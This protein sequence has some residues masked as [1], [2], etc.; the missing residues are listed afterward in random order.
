MVEG[1]TSL[2]TDV[3]EPTTGQGFFLA[4]PYFY[5]G[6]TAIDDTIASGVG[7]RAIATRQGDRGD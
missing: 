3:R 6:T 5:Y 4:T 2:T 7:G 1:N